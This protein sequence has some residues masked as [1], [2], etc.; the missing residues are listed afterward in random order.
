V[1]VEVEQLDGLGHGWFRR[2]KD[3][4]SYTRCQS[5]PSFR[6]DWFVS[7][8]PEPPLHAAGAELRRHTAASL[9]FYDRFG[10][11]CQTAWGRFATVAERPEAV[12]EQIPR[13][14]WVVWQRNGAAWQ[15]ERA[16]GRGADSH[17]VEREQGFAALY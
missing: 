16:V 8:F 15:I 1:K 3:R 17:P 12:I 7:H 10:A 13:K 6:A 9:W 11:P 4:G 14:R 5:V 2:R